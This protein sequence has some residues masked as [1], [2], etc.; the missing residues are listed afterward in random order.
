MINI[1]ESLSAKIANMGFV[2]ACLVVCIHTPE[3]GAKGNAA[4]E[5]LRTVFPAKITN[6]A[7]PFF[8]AVSGFLLYGKTVQQGWY[9]RES[10]KR[11][12]S[13]LIPYLVLNLI[14]FAIHEGIHTYAVAKLGYLGAI[15][16]TWRTPFDVFGLLWTRVPALGVL[17]YVRAL[18]LY[19][20]LAPVLVWVIRQ[21]RGVVITAILMLY[22]LYWLWF[23]QPWSPMTQLFEL[24]ISVYGLFYFFLGMCA[25]EFG[26][27][28]LRTSRSVFVLIASLGCAWFGLSPISI[29][30]ALIGLLGV[31]PSRPFPRILTANAF[32]IYVFHTM[33]FY[34]AMVVMKYFKVY[35]FRMTGFGYLTYLLVGVAGGVFIGEMLRRNKFAR[36]IFLG[37]R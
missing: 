29:P 20:L 34:L 36:L 32:S 6:I 19:V 8:F 37:G 15:E 17:W 24:G 22:S 33:M 28:S 11:F 35:S 18:M 1:T 16:L 31:I 3:F 4:Y 10:Y 7:V 12:W 23:V 25:R 2:C 14:W 26:S 30:L 27:P 9:K 13:L 21:S 5:F